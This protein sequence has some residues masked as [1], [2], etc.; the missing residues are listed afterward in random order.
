MHD[1]R[2][3][4]H[5]PLAIVVESLDRALEILPTDLETRTIL[6]ANLGDP[7]PIGHLLDGGS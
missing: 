6:R 4:E 2:T 7:G 5:D 1:N 3:A